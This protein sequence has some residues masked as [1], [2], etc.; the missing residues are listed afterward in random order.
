MAGTSR[1]T[2]ALA[3]E[4][5]AN[6]GAQT[7]PESITPTL[8]DTVLQDIIAS[9]Y[10]RNDDALVPSPINMTKAQLVTAIGASALIDKQYITITDRA[11]GFPLIIQA[12]GVNKVSPFGIWIKSGVP[13]AVI[14][15]YTGS[16]EL[17][18]F[19]AFYDS[20]ASLNLPNQIVIA[21][22]SKGAGKYL[23]S[24]ANGKGTWASFPATPV[25]A[26]YQSGVTA[27]SGMTGSAA[28]MMGLAGAITPS[29][30]GNVLI[31]V[32]G[33][34]GSDDVA[35]VTTLILKTGTG[36][37]PINGAGT[38]GTSQLTKG[39]MFPSGANRNPFSMVVIAS[40]I[41]GNTYWID[42]AIKNTTNGAVNL[43]S[44]S[45]SAIEQS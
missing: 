43:Y 35:S 44:V 12:Q 38:T 24:D 18:T 23:Q 21:D 6:I 45:I 28:L 17:F 42:M 5:T 3:A 41:V 9:M 15:V 2:A 31:M 29:N 34:Y 39:L 14:M 36:T 33:E 13:I 40:L 4:S 37:A 8:N 1:N 19:S 26:S 7:T 10:N 11:D 27:P 22:S 32:T 20:S 30:T 25:N 16:G